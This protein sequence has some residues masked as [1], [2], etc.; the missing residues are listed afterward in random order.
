MRRMFSKNQIKEIAKTEADKV[1]PSVAEASA[2]NV[3][4]LNEDK[5]PEWTEISGGT[6]L[7]KHIIHFEFNEG[8]VYAG[9][10]SKC[11]LTLISTESSFTYSNLVSKLAEMKSTLIYAKLMLCTSYDPED[12]ESAEYD[13]LDTNLYNYDESLSWVSFLGFGVNNWVYIDEVYSTNFS[14]D[15]TPL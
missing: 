6:K 15:V 5:V 4:A 3:L 12:P 8:D 14:D 2:G 10:P 11:N 13:Y 7:Y 9:N 1:L